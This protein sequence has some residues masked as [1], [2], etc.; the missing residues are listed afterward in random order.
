[1]TALTMTPEQVAAHY[2]R[3]GKP[4]PGVPTP[5]VP[6]VMQE[7]H[8]RIR[9]SPLERMNRTERAYAER[10]DAAMLPWAYEGLSFRLDDGTFYRPDF[11]VFGPA[12]LELHEVKGGHIWEDSLVKFKWAR[13][14]ISMLRW[15]MM[16]KVNGEWRE[17]R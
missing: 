16:Q 7:P 15:L 14:R 10:L 6:A 2:R 13:Q 11:L 9:R 5:K 3:I 1:M 8:A 17:I 4:A 12:G